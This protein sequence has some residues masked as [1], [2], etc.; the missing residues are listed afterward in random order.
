M[1]KKDCPK[2][3]ISDNE[4]F[5]NG[6]LWVDLGYQ[7]ILDFYQDLDIAIPY[8]KSRKSKKILTLN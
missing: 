2:K 6:T 1:L 4:F 7:G 3:Q 5:M 8:K